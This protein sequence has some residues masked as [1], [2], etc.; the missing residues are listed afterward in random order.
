MKPIRMKQVA[1]ADVV[2]PHARGGIASHMAGVDEDGGVWERMEG[3]DGGQ[4]KPVPP[5]VRATTKRKQRNA[6]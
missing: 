3:L 1:L 4:W 2:S 6:K 5:P